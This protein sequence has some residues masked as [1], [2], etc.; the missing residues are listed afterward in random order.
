MEIDGKTGGYQVICFA[1]HS[2]EVTACGRFFTRKG[3]CTYLRTQANRLF[4]DEADAV[5]AYGSGQSPKGYR[6]DE[7]SIQEQTDADGCYAASVQV[8]GCLWGW[9]ILEI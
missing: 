2:L 1:F 3:A 8:G 7:A 6:P 5:S 4:R 9:G